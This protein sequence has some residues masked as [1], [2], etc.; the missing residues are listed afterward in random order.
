MF[1]VR[2]GMTLL[3]VLIALT[4]LSVGLIGLVSATSRCLAAARQ[5]RDFARARELL[6]RVDVEAPLVPELGIEAGEEEDS[7]ETEAGDV[8]WTRDI[9]HL[10]DDDELDE[11]L[12][13]ITTSIEFGDEGNRRRESATTLLY[14]PESAEGLRP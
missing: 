9:A 7:F 4:I 14:A 12:F 10:G 8:R 3:E 5:T 1:S 11:G 6:A 2:S 13:R